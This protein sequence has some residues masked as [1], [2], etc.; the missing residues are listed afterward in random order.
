MGMVVELYKKKKTKWSENWNHFNIKITRG[1]RKMMK[2]STKHEIIVK[3]VVI[4]Y[5]NMLNENTNN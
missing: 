4:W 1:Q 2:L 5:A 3:M